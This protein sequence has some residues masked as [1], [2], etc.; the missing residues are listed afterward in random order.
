MEVGRKNKQ[1]LRRI[2]STRQIRDCVEGS[3]AVKR[4]GILY[5][6]IPSG[7]TGVQNTAPT[8]G[9]NSNKSLSDNNLNISEAP[10]Y[11]SNPAYSAYIQRAKFPDITKS[12]L[13]GM[14]G[15]ATREDPEVDFPAS[16]SYLENIATIDGASINELYAECVSEVL[17]AGRLAL[18]FDV[19][20]DNTFYI[21][22]YYSESYVNWEFSVINGMR[23]QT[24]AEFETVEFTDGEECL[25]T[26]AYC[27]E[28]DE[29]TGEL[30][31]V[32][33]KY[34][35]HRIYDETEI[36]VQG[37]RIGFLPIANINS[38]TE[39]NKPDIDTLPLLGISDCALDIYRH[40]ADLNQNHF[41]ACNQTLVFTGVDGDDAPT[42]MGSGV[43]ICLSDSSSDAKYVSA[44]TGALDHVSKY[45]EGVFA[46]AVHYGANLLG[47][48]KKSAESAEALSLRQA[49][50]GASLLTVVL[51]VGNGINRI[52]QMI[53]SIKTGTVSD[54]KYF[55]PN[56]SFAEL[57]LSAQEINA[58]ISGWMS[59]AVSHLTLLDNL[60]QAGRL[61]DR[62]PDEEIAQI[63]REGVNINGRTENTESGR[64]VEGSQSTRWAVSDDE[65]EDSAGSGED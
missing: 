4:A 27:L 64:S 43:A 56:T 29:E 9:V 10:W 13:K 58:L 44:T 53:D 16:L 40:S 20:D 23:K 30:F 6:P 34:K 8:L 22:Q 2:F 50:A 48:S 24:Y 33:R 26:L 46:E 37:K 61:G 57:H 39:A 18:V 42:L 41:Q 15:I 55:I 14:V 38:E 35:D 1:Y 12:T 52:I 62:S 36:R 63:E 51:A 54:D 47:P 60:A 7:M 21:A 3:D 31:C 59:G 65:R 25:K 19:R 11:H 5:L 28:K 45:I 49:N 17:K 32:V